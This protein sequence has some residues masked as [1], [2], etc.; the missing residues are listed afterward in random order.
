MKKI[1]LIAALVT[2]ICVTGVSQNAEKALKAN[3][4]YS[5]ADL[6]ATNIVLSKTLA[7]KAPF[8][9]KFEGNNNMNYCYIVKSAI[10]DAQGTVIDSGTHYCDPQYTYEVKGDLLTVKYPLVKWYYKVKPL[11]NGDIELVLSPNEQ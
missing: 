3:K 2:G 9:V 5:N 10:M 1:F 11:K 4:W 6:G 8:D 7:T